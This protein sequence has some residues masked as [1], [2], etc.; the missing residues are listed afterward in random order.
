MSLFQEVASLLVLSTLF[1][2]LAVKLRPA[3]GSRAAYLRSA[4]R[5]Q[6]SAAGNAC[7]RAGSIGSPQ[8]RQSP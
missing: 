1:G 8:R 5:R 2:G 3:A 6:N 4:Q 7:K